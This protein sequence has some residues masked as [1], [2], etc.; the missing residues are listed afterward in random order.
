MSMSR[1]SSSFQTKLSLESLEA[2]SL[3]SSIH[4]IVAAH[5]PEHHPAIERSAQVVSA[6]SSSASTK[7]TE[8]HLAAN[9]TSESSSTVT[10]TAKF[11]SELKKGGEVRELSVQV[12]GAAAG[13]VV[14]V[15]ITDAAGASTPVGSITIK[16][17]GTGKLKLKA[18]LPAVV[19][20]TSISISSADGT[21]LAKGDFA[22]STNK[23]SGAGE[24]HDDH[25]ETHLL[26]SLTDTNSKLTS[27]V[28]YESETE[29]GLV[30]TQL[31]VQVKGANP[32]AVIDVSVSA[33]GTSPSVLIGTI[34]VGADGTG[35]LKLNTGVPAIT[36]NSTVTLTY[37]GAPAADGSPTTTTLTALFILPT[38]S[39]K[40][41][42]H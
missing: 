25:A 20:G 36:T 14:N 7:S 1:K 34:T 17:D 15:T 32:G 9:L 30:L 5:V 37:P 4:S 10:A 26:A 28:Q 23:P 24:H 18:G 21:L 6:K 19:A 29:H 3:L 22:V 33:D 2:R 38:P 31:K 11:E 41:P 35:R 12:K 8:T 13:S 27:T 39:A 16:A 42:G 40:K